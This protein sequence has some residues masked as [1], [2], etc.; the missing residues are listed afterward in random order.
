MSK[1]FATFIIAL[2]CVLCLAAR[3]RKQENKTWTSDFHLDQDEL[4]S[5][6]RN[7]YFVLEPGYTLVLEA[8]S[9]RLTITVLNETRTIDKV[10]TRIVEEREMKDGQ[11]VEVSRNYFAISKRTNNVYY[12][13]EDVDIYKAGKIASHEGAWLAGVNGARFGL[14]MPGSPTLRARYYQEL[15][16]GLAM[17]R[18][19]IVSLSGVLKTPA[20]EFKEVL[21]I[22]ETT[23]LERGSEPKY[24]ARGVGLLQDGTLKLVRYGKT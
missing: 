19:E 23:P 18:A 10:E 24:Y 7:P 9:E 4:V 5:T 6:G 20:G 12:F 8:G 15:A 14:M 1:S 2:S 3:T 16:P 21:K 11:L 13:G 22:V 17:D